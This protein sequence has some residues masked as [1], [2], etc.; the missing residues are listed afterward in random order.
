M[1][2]ADSR[3]TGYRR[4]WKTTFFA[5]LAMQGFGLVVGTLIFGYV[6]NSQP[7]SIY[8]VFGYGKPPPIVIDGF[9]SYYWAIPGAI[10]GLFFTLYA[11]RS[12]QP[13]VPGTK[14]VAPSVGTIRRASDKKD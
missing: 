6:V 4:S 5:I 8:P 11:M 12:R 7:P 13:I 10:I 2:N 9:T 3:E 14:P 1:G